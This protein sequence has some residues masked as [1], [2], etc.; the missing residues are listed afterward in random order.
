MRVKIIITALL[1]L[2]GCAKDTNVVD[3]FKSLPPKATFEQYKIYDLVEQNNLQCA[4]MI[5]FIGDDPVYNYYFTCLKSDQIFLVNDI[6]AIRVKNAFAAGLI[7]LEQL[8]EL[9]IIARM[10]K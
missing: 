10:E 7:T 2:T 6:E 4:E 5:E 3:N 9:N 8:Y 1:L